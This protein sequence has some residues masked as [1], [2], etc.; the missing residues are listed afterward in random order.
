MT[1]KTYQWLA[2]IHEGL[3]LKSM[4]RAL[5]LVPNSVLVLLSTGGLITTSPLLHT[6]T[7]SKAMFSPSLSQSVHRMRCWQPRD[8]L[9]KVFYKQSKHTSESCFA[10][11]VCA[12][13]YL[14]ICVHVC[15]V[16]QYVYVH[17][18]VCCVCVCVCVCACVRAGVCVCVL[19]VCVVCVCVDM[20]PFQ[21]PLVHLEGL[22]W[23]PWR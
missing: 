8:S 21:W 20:L 13:V 3:Q 7:I 22:W 1:N 19:C 15:V 18:L 5:H 16:V 12:C 9:S 10:V 6:S 2:C 14:Y 11:H 17:V 4:G 23:K